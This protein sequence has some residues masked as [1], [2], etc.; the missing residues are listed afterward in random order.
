MN[1]EAVPLGRF[2]CDGRQKWYKCLEALLFVVKVVPQASLV[3][4]LFGLLYEVQ[5]FDIM[6]VTGTFTQ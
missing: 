4:S 1:P 3:F 2:V 6:K 5:G